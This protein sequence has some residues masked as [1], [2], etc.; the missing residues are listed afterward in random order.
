MEPTFSRITDQTPT[1]T[2]TTIIPAK[3]TPTHTPG[4]KVASAT[5]SVPR[6][7]ITK[8]T[9]TAIGSATPTKIKFD[10]KQ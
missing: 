1:A 2:D 10:G 5:S 3:G 9:L 6:L 7:P 8:L 4:I